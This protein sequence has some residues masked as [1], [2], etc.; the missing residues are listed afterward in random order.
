M[1][2]TSESDDALTRSLSAEN[3]QLQQEFIAVLQA[4]SLHSDNTIRA[5]AT[6]IKAFLLWCQDSGFNPLTLRH[7]QLRLYL[8][9]LDRSGYTRR[10]VNRHLSAV[11]GFYRCL[12]IQGSVE[13]SP[14]DVLQGPKQP[15]S[16]PRVM[17]TQD[18]QRLLSVYDVEDPT[19]R[20][21]RNKA[22]L[23]LLYACGLRVSEASSLTLSQLD[24]KQ[25]LAKPFGKGSK[26]RIVP[27]HATAAK[28]IDRY[29]RL[30]RDELLRDEP[31]PNVFI[32]NSGGVM[33]TNAIREVFKN[34]LQIA[35]LDTSLSPHAVRHTF[36]TDLLSGGADLRSVQEMLGH[37]SLSTTQIYTHLTP[38]HLQKEHHQAHPRA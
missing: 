34:A 16:L 19:P 38:E 23:E 36:A 13:T 17:T 28:A 24:L 12:V 6:D 5:Y 7:Q 33:S 27:M 15:K 29:L 8:A 37:S 22:L 26:E 14:A 31:L 2:T 30:G 4:E 1:G 9:Y 10:T 32:S 20:D 3:V 21:L 18:M 11:K 25:R 35:G